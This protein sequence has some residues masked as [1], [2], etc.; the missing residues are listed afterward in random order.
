MWWVEFWWIWIWVRNLSM[1]RP[2]RHQEVMPQDFSD[3]GRYCT[4]L[5]KILVKQKQNSHKKHMFV[6]VP[7]VV[8]TESR[9]THWVLWGILPT[10]ATSHS[11]GCGHLDDFLLQTLWLIECRSLKH[12]SMRMQ[13]KI[14]GPKLFQCTFALQ[15]LGSAFSCRA[16]HDVNCGKL[17]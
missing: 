13:S 4:P 5:P 12:H 1:L 16:E 6:R 3:A 10:M 9:M 14:F 15:S 17:T 2:V 7:C 11:G 8:I